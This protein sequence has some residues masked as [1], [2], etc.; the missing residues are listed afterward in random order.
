[1]LFALEWCE[2]CWAVRKLFARCGI[3][4][5]A[6]D[7][8]SVAYQNDNR[9]GKIRAALTART[10]IGT[11]PQVF[12]GGELIGGATETFDAWRAGKLQKLLD[13]EPRRVRRDAARSIR[14][15]SCRRGCTRAS[16]ELRT[17]PPVLAA[18]P[19]GAEH[20]RRARAHRPRVDAAARG[21]RGA[22][23]V[24]RDRHRRHAGLARPHAR[25]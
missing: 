25:R 21:G 15:R 5:R 23:V 14:T 19:R 17:E 2:F 6:V 12:V 16:E 11:I 3:P 8:D 22:L 20:R 9:G 10:A 24:S 13:G 1:M 4:Y 18:A 7:L